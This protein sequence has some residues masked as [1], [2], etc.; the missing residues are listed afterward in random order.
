MFASASTK[1]VEKIRFVNAGCPEVQ[2]EKRDFEWAR[3]ELLRRVRIG[4]PFYILCSLRSTAKD[5]RP[6]GAF[7]PGSLP[8]LFVAR[9]GN[10]GALSA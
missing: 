9:A 4:F 2:R 7:R 1:A 5:I 8:V 10:G 6:D 3:G